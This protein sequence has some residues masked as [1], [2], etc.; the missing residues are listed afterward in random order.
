ML[1]IWSFLLE[2]PALGFNINE[3]IKRT[4]IGRTAA[5]N[6]ISLLA[7]Q[8][9]VNLEKKGN[10]NRV[11]L[12]PSLHS[13]SL[14]LFL[15]TMAFKALDA[16][17]RLAIILFIENLKD[18]AMSAVVFGS[19][20]AGKS[21]NDIDI[22][23]IYKSNI[24]QKAVLKAR[25]LA[26]SISEKPLNIH[27]NNSDTST[28][29]KGICVKGFEYYASLFEQKSREKEEFNEAMGWIL[30]ASNNLADKGLL[31]ECIEKAV[32]HLAFAYSF[33]KKLPAFT[34][35]EAFENFREKYSNAYKCRNNLN[36]LKK[37][38]VEI[39]KE[40]FK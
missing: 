10:Q 6:A 20:L 25:A 21:Y 38:A 3:I 28:S 1:K 26:E 4:S 39:G 40:I 16:N 35:N 32:M 24:D 17:A 33:L 12:N 9:I 27:F 18:D 34:K 37:A 2:E 8:G 29:P 23:V 31:T 30:S 22:A 7:K 14:K 13:F 15:D 11:S 19:V 5:F 36:P